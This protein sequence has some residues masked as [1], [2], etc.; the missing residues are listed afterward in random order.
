MFKDNSKHPEAITP[1]FFFPNLGEGEPQGK[2]DEQMLL[3]AQM[4]AAAGMGKIVT[5]EDKD[6]D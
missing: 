5:K 4:Y 1:A 2:S 6:G 3:T